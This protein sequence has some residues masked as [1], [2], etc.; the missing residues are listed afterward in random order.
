MSEK[1]GGGGKP[2]EFDESSGQ[3]RQNTSY[4]DIIKQSSNSSVKSKKTLSKEDFYG[5]EIQL[6]EGENAIEIMLTHKEGHI[7]NAFYRKE[8]GYIDLV[9]GRDGKHGAGLAHL[10]ERRDEMYKTGQGT[11]TGVNMARKIP[12]IVNNGTFVEDD[13]GRFNFEYDGYRVGVRPSFDGVKVNATA[14]VVETLEANASIKIT[15]STIKKV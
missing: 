6:K 1:I 13:K 5:K 4:N 15:D 10:I 11:I 3:Y 14:V 9:W 8:M 12:E 7:K 2:Q